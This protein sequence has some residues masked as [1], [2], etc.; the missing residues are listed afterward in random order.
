VVISVE[1]KVVGDMDTPLKNG[2]RIQF[3]KALVGG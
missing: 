1:Q 2:Q 3:F